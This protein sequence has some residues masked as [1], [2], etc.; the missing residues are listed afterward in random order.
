[1]GEEKRTSIKLR[2]TT[3]ERFKRYGRKGDSYEDIVTRILC[4]LEDPSLGRTALRKIRRALY[5]E[6]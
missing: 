4:V 5:P 2:Q 1:V 3:L 6:F